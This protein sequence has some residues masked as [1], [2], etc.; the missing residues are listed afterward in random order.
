MLDL[1]NDPSLTL[2]DQLNPPPPNFI[3]FAAA[4]KHLF[5]ESG[6]P[7]SVILESST[8]NPWPTPQIETAL[9]NNTI[10]KKEGIFAGCQPHNDIEAQK[11]TQNPEIPKKNAAFTRTFSKSSH[12]LLHSSPLLHESGTQGKLFRKTCSDELFYFGWI[13]WVE[14]PP[15]TTTSPLLLML[16]F[17]ATMCSTVSS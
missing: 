10:T 5:T 4:L 16:P 13:F 15:L 3:A 12:E 17:C 8:L 1:Q 6:L 11:P 9:P 14:F 7:S 2:E